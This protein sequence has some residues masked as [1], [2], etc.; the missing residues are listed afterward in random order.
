[1]PVVLPAGATKSVLVTP[2]TDSAAGQLT[3]DCGSY[4]FPQS[5]SS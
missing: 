1:M 3:M 5:G 2:R 4:V